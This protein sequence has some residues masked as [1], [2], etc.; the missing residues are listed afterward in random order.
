MFITT[1]M[2][3]RLVNPNNRLVQNLRVIG[4]KRVKC[5]RNHVLGLAIQ[6]FC[7]N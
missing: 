2:A 1:L 4:Q 5:V 6:A 7:D 3:C